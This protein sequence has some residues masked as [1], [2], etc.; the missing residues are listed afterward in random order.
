MSRYLLGVITQSLRGGSPT[1]GPIFNRA[2]VCTWA[3][4]EFYMYARYK[5]HNN[6]TLSSTEDALHRFNTF[7]NVF[8]L[9]RA[10]KKGKPTAITLITEL[11][12]QGKEDEETIAE[13]SM[14]S[15]KRL[16]M[17]ACRDYISQEMYVS[18]ELDAN[19]NF[20]LIHLMSHWVE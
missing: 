20:R 4:K 6:A 19:F 15:K 13:T 17:N 16:E 1:Q 8:L 18:K 12:K 9:G 11:V 2:I 7:K 3:L 10:G 5:S 14:P